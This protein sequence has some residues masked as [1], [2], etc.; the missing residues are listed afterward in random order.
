VARVSEHRTHCNCPPGKGYTYY[1]GEGWRNWCEERASSFAAYCW[2]CNSVCRSEGEGDD[3][4]PTVTQMVPAATA[5]DITRERDEARRAV[6]KLSYIAEDCDGRCAH[7]EITGGCYAGNLLRHAY[8]ST[9]GTVPS[10]QPAPSEA[11]SPTDTQLLDALV[12]TLTRALR[13]SVALSLPEGRDVDVA[14]AE[15]LEF[16]RQMKEPAQ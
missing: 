9:G 16:A 5:A 12:D 1:P 14:V 3:W 11:A 4:H 6:V 2:C 8:T 15:L 7:C 13:L 10:E